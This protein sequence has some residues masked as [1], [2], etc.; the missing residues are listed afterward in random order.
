VFDDGQFISCSTAN[1]MNAGM[2][3]AKAEYVIYADGTMVLGGYGETYS[4]KNHGT[5]PFIGYNYKIK[6]LKIG[7]GIT[8][9]GSYF[10]CYSSVAS[11]KFAE[12]SNL[13]QIGTAAF[14]ED[15]A[16]RTIELPGSVTYLSN[17]AFGKC[18][19]LAKVVLTAN[20]TAINV[21][22][23]KKTTNVTLYVADGSYALEFAIANNIPYVINSETVV[24]GLPEATGTI[25]NENGT[26][27]YYENGMR[28]Y[29]GLIY[30]DGALYYVRSS[31]QLAVNTTYW[32]TKT[33][34][35]VEAGNYK[36]DAEGKMIN[37]PIE[38]P[39]DSTEPSIPEATGTI[40]NE[41]GTLYYYENGVRKYAGLIYLDG[42]YYYVRSNG[43]LA[44]STTYWVTKH[45][46]LLPAANYTFD[47][48]GKMIV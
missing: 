40:V 17:I 45:N 1:V 39:G 8:R 37:P 23:F 44:V 42:N 2:A 15:Y 30:L 16:L 12:G 25:V 7:A 28:K 18:E 5:R 43:Q 6:T 36:F 48:E 4:F 10:M 26:L 20:V 34:D 13:Q 24:P 31:G 3:G 47:A 33:N 19:N 38:L 14:Y 29:A 11:I 21:N 32:V 9:I 27:Y 22:A 46:D 41:G 35:L